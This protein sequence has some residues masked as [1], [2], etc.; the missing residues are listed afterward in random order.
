MLIPTDF[1]YNTFIEDK[2]GI[3]ILNKSDAYSENFGKQWKE[4]SDTQIDSKNNFDI[5]KQY[6]SQI[7]SNKIKLPYFS[8][9]QDHV[10]HQ[11][12]VSVDDRE[13][14]VDYLKNNQVKTLI[15]YPI[16]PHKQKA[17]SKYKYLE[18]PITEHI[19]N[20]VVS[21]PISPIMTDVQVNKVIQLLNTY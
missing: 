10:F 8:N 3:F 5:S 2:D 7:V 16:A 14:F 20:T 6:L 17:L 19:H 18:L 12:V 15:H 4:Y 1:F 13:A 9:K 21:I 11:F